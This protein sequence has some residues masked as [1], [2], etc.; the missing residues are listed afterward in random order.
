MGY[1]KWEVRQLPITKEFYV[2]CGTELIACGLSEAN[3]RL[4]AQAPRLYEAVLTAWR[5]LI[6][7]IGTIAETE[8]ALFYAIKETGKAETIAEEED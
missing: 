4:I 7:G 5:H 8:S 1:T 6:L 2:A 3:A